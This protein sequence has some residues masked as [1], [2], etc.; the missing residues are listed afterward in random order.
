MMTDFLMMAGLVVIAAFFWQLRQM[1]EICR[2]FAE[3]EVKRQRV[4]LLSVAMNSARPCLGAGLGW[5]ANFQFEFSTDGINQYKG[6][7]LMIGK[8]IQK[9]EWPIFP[10]PE[11]EQ[12]P[13]SRGKVSGGCGGGCR[14]GGCH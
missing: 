4:Q 1:A 5:K 13:T 6:H 12:A 2:Q 3:R 8:R 9:I 10:E 14:S 7:I 11:W